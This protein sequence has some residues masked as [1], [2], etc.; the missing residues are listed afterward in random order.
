VSVQLKGP[1][2]QRDIAL[3]L[4]LLWRLEGWE[5]PTDRSAMHATS[6]FVEH[7]GGF[8]PC[9]CSS[10][11]S[12]VSSSKTTAAILEP[13]IKAIVDGKHTAMDGTETRL[14]TAAVEA[15]VYNMLGQY[16]LTITE[17]D[18]TADRCCLSAP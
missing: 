5:D 10:C 12:L 17:I 18:E 2:I 11:N 15:A 3:L 4:R 7:I 8:E 16:L 14:T 9:P 13:H 6:Y 1:K